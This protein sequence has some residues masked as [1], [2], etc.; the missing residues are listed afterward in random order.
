MWIFVC[1]WMN[2]FRT[3]CQFLLVNVCITYVAK[4][5]L[6]IDYY[7]INVMVCVFFLWHTVND[8]MLFQTLNRKIL[9]IEW[10]CILSQL[11]YFNKMFIPKGEFPILNK[12]KIEYLLS[13]FFFVFG[14][15]N[16]HRIRWALCLPNNWNMMQRLYCS[17]WSRFT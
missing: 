16:L 4:F 11:F 3:I 9:R 2:I 1:D 6:L 14:V 15:K 13:T 10:F 7:A 8:F 5:V 17:F 12:I